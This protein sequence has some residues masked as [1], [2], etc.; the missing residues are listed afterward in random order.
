M[1]IKDATLESKLNGGVTIKSSLD[2]KAG[3][4]VLRLVVRDA[5]GQTMSAQNGTIE[6]P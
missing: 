6:I 4:Y 2:V 1:K 3:S 5:E